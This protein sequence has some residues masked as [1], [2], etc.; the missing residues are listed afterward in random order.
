MSEGGAVAGPSQSSLKERIRGGG[1]RP[2]LELG[3]TPS[4]VSMLLEG[5]E[6]VSGG[7]RGGGERGG[8]RREDGRRGERK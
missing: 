5:G 6:E 8:E 3:V 7:G 1:L 4:H 2:L